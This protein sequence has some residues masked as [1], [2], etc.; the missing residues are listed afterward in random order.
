[1]DGPIKVPLAQI[2]TREEGDGYV[3][4]VERIAVD[5]GV[6]IT[7]LLVITTGIEGS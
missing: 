3:S 2:N 5:N 4:S 1:M 6:P 7:M